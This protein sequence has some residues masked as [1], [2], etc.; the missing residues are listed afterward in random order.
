MQDQTKCTGNARGSGSPQESLLGC[1]VEI[2]LR[3]SY[4]LEGIL[5]GFDG[6]KNLVVE[7]NGRMTIV[8]G[9]SL[10]GINKK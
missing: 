4:V 7:S 2:E 5:R 9:E 10:K 3:Q 1:A 8:R 6:H